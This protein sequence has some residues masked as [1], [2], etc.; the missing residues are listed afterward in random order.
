[1]VLTDQT[2]MFGVTVAE[3]YKGGPPII[4]K[5]FDVG[6]GA[7]YGLEPGLRLLK[8]STP[9]EL[10][11]WPSVGSCELLEVLKGRRR[12]MY[13]RFQGRP[14][15]PSPPP[16]HT[17]SPPPHLPPEL[18]PAHLR[19]VRNHIRDTKKARVVID[20]NEVGNV[21]FSNNTSCNPEGEE[22]ES[23]IEEDEEEED[24]E[25]D[26]DVD[27]DEY[28]DE[29]VEAVA[30]LA[31]KLSSDLNSEEFLMMHGAKS[32][33]LSGGSS[34]PTSAQSVGRSV[35]DGLSES[36]PT[37][38]GSLQM[39]HASL[40][41]SLVASN[42]T[43]LFSRPSSAGAV[44]SSP[45]SRPASAGAVRSMPT[46]KAQRPASAG[47]LHSS[48]RLRNEGSHCSKPTSV[49]NIPSQFESKFKS[50]N[51]ARPHAWSQPA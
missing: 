34:C 7:N 24:I 29:D 20:V 44:S 10:L 42:S 26:S 6:L 45:I 47:N 9:S 36:R 25:K 18:W 16:K 40:P 21:A 4:T 31:L 14:K 39:S 41:G 32:R 50:C 22:E 8:I 12:P 13:L 17:P 27:D 37:S 33:P 35:S 3:D 15:K 5:V 48:S 23:G 30:P 51:N 49:A 11:E 2:T 43:T 1:M 38:A 19:P 46:R 28:E